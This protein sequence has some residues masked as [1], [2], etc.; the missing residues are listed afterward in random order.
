MFFLLWGKKKKNLL[1]VIKRLVLSVWTFV[2]RNAIIL[3][4]LKFRFW[5][6]LIR[7]LS[8]LL[9]WEMVCITDPNTSGSL[10]WILES[11]TEYFSCLPPRW[12]EKAEKPQ[13]QSD[14]QTHKNTSSYAF[15]I[16]S[17]SGNAV[18][19]R[20]QVIALFQYKALRYSFEKFSVVIQDESYHVY[21]L[22]R[23]RSETWQ[24]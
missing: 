9:I 22:F 14:T 4:V 11:I 15:P 10:N 17:C 21:P 2:L 1:I 24:A 23:I 16:T 18:L 3:L 6:F 5:V 12:T 13:A 20:Y 8:T 7:L 19:Q